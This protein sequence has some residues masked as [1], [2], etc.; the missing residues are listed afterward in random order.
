MMHFDRLSVTF[1]FCIGFLLV[2]INLFSEND[3]YENGC[4]TEP[5]EVNFEDQTTNLKVYQTLTF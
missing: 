3:I 4:H 1:S 5:V 2:Q